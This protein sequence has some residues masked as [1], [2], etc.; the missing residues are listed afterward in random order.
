VTV[1]STN[2]GGRW[3][4][5]RPLLVIALSAGIAALTAAGTATRPIGTARVHDHLS[6]PDAVALR[7][8]GAPSAAA[9]TKPETPADRA[10]QFETLLGHHSI[11]AADM[12]RARLRADPDFAQAADAALSKNTAALSG[13]VEVLA[14]DK[15]EYQ[16]GYL[17]KTHI[18]ALFNYARGLADHDTAVREAARKSLLDYEGRLA[19]FFAGLSHG[20]L[21]P[22]TAR[23]AVT[24]HVDHLLRQADAYAQHDYVTAGALYR[25]SYDHTFGLGKAIASAVLTPAQ[26]ATLAAPD[27]TLRSELAR[28]LGEHVALAVGAMRSG[29]AHWPDFTAVAGSLNANTLDLTG[30]I[31]GI[32]GA[33]A[34]HAFQPLWADHVDQLIRYTAAVAGHNDGQRRAAVARL[35]EFEQQFAAFLDGA[36]AHRL[37]ASAM[38]RGMAM[39]DQMLMRQIDAFAAKKYQQAHEIAYTTYT[40]AGGYSGVLGA[41]FAATTMARAP[42]GGIQTGYGGMATLVERR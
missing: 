16:F 38:A 41:A 19:S 1:N 4:V 14:G 24:M 23:A 33:P 12:M 32:F 34:A 5:R 10:I 7:L 20:R 21:D 17:W 39:H 36:T 22:V 25:Q 27:W 26:A 9:R 40:D 29:Y 28:L 8:L 15:A 13:L 18:Q 35:G 31:D 3:L 37:A 30:A 2:H 42:R 11:L 6:S